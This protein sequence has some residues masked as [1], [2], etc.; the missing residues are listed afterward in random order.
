LVVQLCEEGEVI[1]IFSTGPAS[2]PALFMHSLYSHLICLFCGVC[3]PVE[4]R[5]S[6]L[7]IKQAV[8]DLLQNLAGHMSAAKEHIRRRQIEVFRRCDGELGRRLDQAVSE[9]AGRVK[10]VNSGNFAVAN[11]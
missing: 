4:C 6:W 9:K 7:G 1:D 10:Q 11:L 2:F 3:S 5:F 8:D